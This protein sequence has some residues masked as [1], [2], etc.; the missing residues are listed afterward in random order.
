MLFRLAA[1]RREAQLARNRRVSG[2]TDET[3]E[4]PKPM[5]S[6]KSVKLCLD[7]ELFLVS[8]RMTIEWVY[9]RLRVGERE[10]LHFDTSDLQTR[11]LV[12]QADWDLVVAQYQLGERRVQLHCIPEDDSSPQMEATDPALIMD[13]KDGDLIPKLDVARPL[14]DDRPDGLH[15]LREFARLSPRPPV[16]AQENRVEEQDDGWGPMDAIDQDASGYEI[17]CFLLV[18]A[19]QNLAALHLYVTVCV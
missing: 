15:G 13:S 8:P 19:F 18:F 14:C 3:P 12:C 7:G 2:K 5:N 4:T 17:V 10:R 6:A 9:Q 16:P 11:S 1:D